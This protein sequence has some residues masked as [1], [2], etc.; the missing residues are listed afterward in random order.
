[1]PKKI[2]VK[3]AAGLTVPHPETGAPMRECTTARTPAIIR[4]IKCG[5]LVVVTTPPKKKTA[6]KKE[7]K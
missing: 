6:P 7:T 5:D 4:Y 2:R 1:M 3:P